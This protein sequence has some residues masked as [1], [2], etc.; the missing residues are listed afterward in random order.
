MPSTTR[1]NKSPLVSPSPSLP[2]TRSFTMTNYTPINDWSFKFAQHPTNINFS[3]GLNDT[4]SEN[5]E[6][7]TIDCLFTTAGRTAVAA[8]AITTLRNT[9]IDTVLLTST[10]DRSVVAPIFDQMLLFAQCGAP[11]R[12]YPIRTATSLTTILNATLAKTK[13]AVVI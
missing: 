2:Q 6:D 4:Y 13:T 12:R 5:F 10:A 11:S 9:L 8:D 3:R 7:A 1:S